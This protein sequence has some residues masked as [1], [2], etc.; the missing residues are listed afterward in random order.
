MVQREDAAFPIARNIVATKYG[1]LPADAVEVTK[2]SILDTV[3]VVL[4]ASGM[5]PSVKAIVDIVREGGG[6]KESTIFSFGDKVPCWMAAYTN[7]SMAQALDYDDVYDEGRNHNAGAVIPAT[8]AIAERLGKVSGKD[9]ITAA[10]L[11]L[12]VTARMAICV[13]QSKLGYEDDWFLSPLFGSYGAT[14]AAGKLL[15]LNESPMVNALGIVFNQAAG[16]MEMSFQPGAD[17][18]ELY[19]AFPGF[20]GVMSA[21]WAS[22]GIAGVRNCLESRAGLFNMYFR[23][24][25]DRDILLDQLGKRFQG[26][27]TGFKPWPTCRLSQAHIDAAYNLVKKYDIKPEQVSKIVVH[28]C[29]SNKTLMEPIEEKKKPRFVTFAKRSIPYTLGVMIVRRNILISDFSESSLKDPAVLAIAD[30]VVAKYAPELFAPGIPPAIV[31]IVT[32]DGKTF[33]WRTAHP[34]GHP[35]NPMS[36]EELINK[37]RDCLSY[38][39]KKFDRSTADKITDSIMNLEKIDNVNEI[40]RLLG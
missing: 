1:N 32:K 13:C 19:S 27:L 33:T 4:A 26:S 22:K 20:N 2:R 34:Y 21:L 9:F 7:G 23:G 12:D 38:S 6:K 40:T 39:V 3:G 30:K 14:A 36:R 11:G 16:S 24:H 10:A 31:D 17:V 5:S 18:R 29:D 8:L 37:F 35:K 15:G 28:V 25:Y